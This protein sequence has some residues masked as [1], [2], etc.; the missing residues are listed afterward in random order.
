[1]EDTSGIDQK[2]QLCC[3]YRSDRTRTAD[4]HCFRIFG[5]NPVWYQNKDTCKWDIKHLLI[6]TNVTEKRVQRVRL[7]WLFVSWKLMW[8]TYRSDFVGRVPI[9][10]SHTDGETPFPSL[11]KPCS[12]EEHCYPVLTLSCVRVWKYN[13]KNKIRPKNN[14]KKWKRRQL[15]QKSDLHFASELRSCRRD[16]IATVP[17]HANRVYVSEFG[18]HVQRNSCCK[19]TQK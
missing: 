8:T 3:R 14:L 6:Q 7:L 18:Q 5:S 12:R 19:S 10:E 17:M 13:Y 15:V 11:W 2:T 4:S 9:W 1:V 16:A